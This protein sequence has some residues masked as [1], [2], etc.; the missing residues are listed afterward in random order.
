MNNTLLTQID[1]LE[2]K[3]THTYIQIT[4]S[5]VHTYFHIN[6]KEMS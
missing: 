6:H 5:T 3:C 2:I 4:H 1:K